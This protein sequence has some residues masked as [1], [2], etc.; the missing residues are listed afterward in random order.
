MTGTGGSGTGIDAG[1]TVDNGTVDTSTIASLP[2]DPSYATAALVPVTV[3][4]IWWVV[5]RIRRRNIARGG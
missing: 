4:T 3:L 1:G 5:R 2:V